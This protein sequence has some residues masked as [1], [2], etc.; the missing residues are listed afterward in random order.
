[1]NEL[2]A[3]LTYGGVH[4]ALVDARPPIPMEEAQ[5]L[6]TGNGGAERS[7]GAQAAC[8]R[9]G[10]RLCGGNSG[11]NGS[12]RILPEAIKGLQKVVATGERSLGGFF[13]GKK[14]HFWE[15]CKPGSTCERVRNMPTRCV[16]L[17]F[18][19]GATSHFGAMLGPNP[20]DNQDL[21]DPLLR[22]YLQ[23]RQF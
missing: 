7:T 14:C 6:A 16:G 13:R 11:A 9:R 17:G 3:T 21:R 5:E 20:N 15:C 10:C 18:L 4:E 19:Q 1:M 23:G 22:Q 12:M 8:P 2:L